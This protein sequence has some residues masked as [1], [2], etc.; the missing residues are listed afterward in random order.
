MEIASAVSVLSTTTN[1]T[2]TK[3]Y[4]CLVFWYVFCIVSS[5]I[6][7][8]CNAICIGI[9]F[10]N[11]KLFFK[12]TYQILFG[13][14]ISNLFICGVFRI[15]ENT[16]QFSWFQ[17]N[18]LIGSDLVCKIESPLY[19]AMYSITNIGQ[20]LCSTCRILAVFA[21]F[22]Y[23]KYV[24]ARV[25]LFCQIVISVLFPLVFHLAIWD[26]LI[27]YKLDLKNGDCEREDKSIICLVFRRAAFTFLPIYATFVQYIIILLKLSLSRTRSQSNICHQLRSILATLLFSIFYAVSVSLAW[28]PLLSTES[29]SEIEKVLWYK[30]GFRMC[31][32]VHPVSLILQFL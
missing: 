10:L 32:S 3:P 2:S 11:K 28:S 6:G 19:I 17:R 27:V 1:A 9:Y 4:G 26:T 18:I 8:A 13:I 5:I 23:K 14:F 7:T 22:F 30:F 29:P 25:T 15:F 24:T 12:P 21:P 20:L 16:Q 31:Y